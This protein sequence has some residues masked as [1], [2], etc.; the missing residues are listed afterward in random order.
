MFHTFKLHFLKNAG[1]K[2]DLLWVI[3]PAYRQLTSIW[4][5]IAIAI[6]R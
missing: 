1:L 5:T 6:V 3:V 2:A 4:I